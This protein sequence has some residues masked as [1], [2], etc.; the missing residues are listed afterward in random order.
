MKN[1]KIVGICQIFNELEKG[2]LER[3]VKHIEPLVDALVVYDDGS[4]DGSY[5]YMLKRTPHVIRGA[6]NDFVNE[7]AHKQILL[8]KALEL[9]PDFIL[10]LDADEVLTANA[11]RTKLNELC[12]YCVEKDLDGLDFHELNIWRSHSWRRLDSRYGDGRFTRLWRVRPGMNFGEPE[13]GLHTRVVPPS[14]QKVEKISDVAVIHYGFS[15]KKQLAYK[16]LVYRSHGQRGYNRLDRLISEEKLAT[17]KIPKDLFPDELWIDDEKPQPMPFLESLSYVEAYRDE[18]FRPRFS[19]ICLIY[20]SVEWLKFVHEQVLKYTDMADKEFFFVANDANDAVL[21]YLRDN[22]IPHHVFENTPEQRSE[23]YINNIYRA[24]NFSAKK[25]RGDFLVFINSDMAFSPDWFDNLWKAYNGSNCVASRL[26]ESGKMKPGR[27]GIEKDFGR[28]I[29]TYQ[30]TEFLQ[31]AASIS[32]S[33]VKD[34]G[35]FM[36]LLIRKSHFEN[37]G[38]YPEGNISPESDIFNPII[39]KKD[40]PLISGDNVLMK[41]L[42]SQGIM[43]QTAFNSIAYHFQCGE[44]DSA[45]NLTSNADGTKVAVCNDI[46]TGSMGEKVLWDFLLESLPASVGV[47]KRVVGKDGEYSKN[48][49]EHI[50]RMHPDIKVIIQNASFIRTVDETKYTIAFLQD[51]L[52]AMNKQ[53]KVQEENLWLARKVITNSITTA[54]SYPEYDFEIIPVGIDS[55]LFR[56]MDKS[57]VRKEMGVKDGRVGIF[58]GNFS[59]VKGWSK[60]REC[61]LRFPDIQ[62]IL[63]SKYDETFSAPNARVFNRIPQ[64]EL[65]KLL[66][67]A[68]FFIIGSPVE[69]QCLA[70]L[71]A[72]LCDV[73]VIM[74]NVGIFT[75]FSE[76]ERSRT[77][78]FGEDFISAINDIQNGTFSPRRVVLDRKLTVQDSIERWKRSLTTVF[79]EIKVEVLKSSGKVAPKRFSNTRFRMEQSLRDGTFYY[80]S[81]LSRLDVVTFKELVKSKAPYPLYCRLEK[82]LF[83]GRKVV[84]KITGDNEGSVVHLSR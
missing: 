62:W 43:H 67:C 61:I 59:E 75:Q 32:S 41:K 27:F 68:D 8:A 55:E 45:D 48:A 14:I 72:C 35:L 11:T 80:V 84:K 56:P 26:V 1:N 78:L 18:V 37:V 17:E 30:E 39:A 77:G 65:A 38:G 20:K 33:E 76:D 69:T 83:F 79:Q 73:P 21:K 74:R 15:S 36:P 29:D 49:R 12:E 70:A 22:Y 54:I 52:R 64:Q 66:N 5:E 60:V 28:T 13:S 57:M 58:V 42:R 44:L 47:D 63:V 19:I 2:N 16:Y 40:E 25:A 24:Y 10:W 31:Y 9:S 4:T 81:R 82:M 71:E 7:I 46:V 53:S 3:F 6:K 50:N 23:W 51:D 34:N